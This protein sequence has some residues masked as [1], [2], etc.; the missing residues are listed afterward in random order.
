L[1]LAADAH[2][3]YHT[4]HRLEAF[5]GTREVDSLTEPARSMV[6]ARRNTY[7]RGFRQ[8]VERG[9]TEGTFQVTSSRLT[10]YAILD[11][12]IGISV[13]FR[14]DGPLD[15]EQVVRHYGIMAL[16][17]VGVILPLGENT[18]TAMLRGEL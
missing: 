2:V 18:E 10:S 5:V 17:I 6:L 1:K 7:E 12:G 3:R 16:R 13:W 14:E 15:G 8:I 11:M 9:R 4:R